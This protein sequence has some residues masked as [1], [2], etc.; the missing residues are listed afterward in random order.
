MLRWDSERAAQVAT[1]GGLNQNMDV[2]SDRRIY[3]IE[4][5]KYNQDNLYDHAVEEEHD[6]KKTQVLSA[7]HKLL[8]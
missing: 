2:V 1:S 8:H 6:H 3:E 5:K 7:E 4:K